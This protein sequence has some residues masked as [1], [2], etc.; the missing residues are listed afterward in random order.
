[1]MTKFGTKNKIKPN[2]EGLD[3]RRKGN[4]KKKMK[5]NQIAIKRI[6]IKLE[7]K[8]KTKRHINSN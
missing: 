7:M 1:M 5:K 2:E 8:K 4:E 6:K 3:W